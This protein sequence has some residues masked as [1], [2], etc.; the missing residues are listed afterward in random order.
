MVP[1]KAEVD[2]GSCATMVTESMD[3]AHFSHIV[4]KPLSKVLRNF[5]E[6]LVKGIKVS[7]ALDAY[8]RNKKQHV[9]VYITSSIAS[10][11]LRRNL[12]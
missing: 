12:I 5:D 2:T 9:W 6:A 3:M 8:C 4:F 7:I 1:I 11:I 10:P